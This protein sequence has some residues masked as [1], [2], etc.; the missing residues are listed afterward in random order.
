MYYSRICYGLNDR[1]RLLPT[2]ELNNHIKD[3]EKDTYYSIF[4]YNELQYKHWLE[5]NS[6]A[7]I[8]DVTTSKLVWDFDS[9]SNL[10]KAKEETL[11]LVTRLQN[12][13]KLNEYD[14]ELF[15]SGKKGFTVVVETNLRFTPNQLKELCYNKIGQ[16]LSTL[17]KS[18]YNA[19]RILRVPFTKHQETGLYKLPLDILS[20][21]QSISEIQELAKDQNNGVEIDYTIAELDSSIIPKVAEK[22][23][24]L[25]DI[26]VNKFLDYTSKPSFLTNCKWSLQ[27]GIFHEGDRN[28]ALLCLAATYKN[29]GYALDINY[30][31]LCGVAK[32]Q[33]KYTNQ[34]AFSEEE[35]Y[36]NIICQVYSNH[37]NNG[38]FSCRD[39]NSWL[40][41]YCQSLGTHSCK[42]EKKED[43]VRTFGDIGDRFK[44]YVVNIDQNTVKTGIKSLDDN[45]FIST[46]SS[47]GIIGAAASGK[48]AV[49]LNILNNTSKAGVKSVFASLDMHETRIYEKLMYR[50]SGL[51]REQLYKI[52]QNNQE[53]K[54]VERLKEEFG[55]VF[56]FDK[57]TPT[58]DD[59]YDY[60][61]DCQ[62]KSGEKIKLVVVDYF[63]RIVSDF[64][65]ET[66]GSKRIAG[67]LQDLVK[68]LDIALIT[69]VQ[70]NK[71]ALSGG[72]NSPIY[73]YTKIKGSSFIYQA[74]RQILSIWRPGYHPETA[75]MDKFM[76][77]AILKDDLGE[78]AT[79]PFK[80]D[81]KRGQINELQDHEYQE[82]IQLEEQ[83]AAKEEGSRGWR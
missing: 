29:L 44:N 24:M 15:F 14:I 4:E 58:V 23:P 46:G 57:T 17:D 71:A 45:L 39:K 7:G 40:Y 37:W 49:A 79:L 41:S 68:K 65:D 53:A 67:E 30:R 52:F 56:F 27:N 54:Y 43:Q 34:E 63:E 70:P 19:S 59:I 69:L 28:S 77:M 38:Q 81:G 74:F 61:L 64:N 6:I 78:L 26:E 18:L 12:D 73:D 13:Y 50:I 51:P 62:E 22:E 55:N 8:T 48:T 83:V 31:M 36:N 75:S 82:L 1:G 32:L 47:V 80:W 60:I 33:A 35:I 5:H 11:L 16:G 10:E 20:L 72:V 25:Q 76:K 3:Y 9:I 2:N 42:H 21:E 66:A